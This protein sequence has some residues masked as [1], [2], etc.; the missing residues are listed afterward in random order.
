MNTRRPPEHCSR[1]YRRVLA[2][3]TILFVAISI[4]LFAT[5]MDRG[6]RSVRFAALQDGM[7][8][9]EVI[10]ALKPWS[11]WELQP[12]G[13]T[14]TLTGAELRLLTFFLEGTHRRAAIHG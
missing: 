13:G 8:K 9:F 4:A 5:F 6:T 3:A 2:L 11:V 12:I 7:T 10:I 1:R 14:A